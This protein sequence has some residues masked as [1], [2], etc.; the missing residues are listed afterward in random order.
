MKA[1]HNTLCAPFSHHEECEIV[2]QD[3]TVYSD[4]LQAGQHGDHIPL[5]AKSST[6]IQISAGAHPASWANG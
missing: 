2:S 1:V 6:P 4:L 5:G 3:G